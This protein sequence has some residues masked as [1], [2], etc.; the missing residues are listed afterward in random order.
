MNIH[1]AAAYAAHLL[2][3]RSTAGHGVHSPLMFSFITEVI[4]GRAD[5]DIIEE[6]R[7]LRREMLSDSRAVRVT[8][9]GAGSAVMQG[10]ERS[11][12]QIASVAAL[13]AREVALLARIAASLDRILERVP[14]PQA[15]GPQQ[16]RRQEIARESVVLPV[17]ELEPTGRAEKDHEPNGRPSQGL[18]PTGRAEKD[19]EPNGRPSQGL[20]PTGRAANNLENTSPGEI[21]QP[22]N[23]PVILELG[24]SLGISTLA[25]ALAAPNRRVITVE[26]CPELAAIARE[27]LRRHSASNAEVLNMEFSQALTHLK[28]RGTKVGMAFIDGNH[29]GAALTDY[30]HRIRGM[31]DAMIIVADDIHINRDMHEAWQALTAS[32]FAIASIETFRLG[33][34]FCIHNLTPGHYRIRY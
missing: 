22:D 21:L 26:G 7:R 13:P 2:A 11:I 5:K 27:N 25:L 12:R 14:D 29:R 4:G 33:I 28:E 34:L 9:L 30:S 19:H 15:G 8:D 32:S 10:R 3:A 16:T 18:E 20:E 6:V 31:G 24:T 23:Q 17:H 1:A